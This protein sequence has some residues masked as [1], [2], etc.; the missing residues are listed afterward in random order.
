[1]TKATHKGTCQICG[2][3]QKLPSNRLSNHGYTIDWGFFNGTCAGAHGLPF[4][5]STDLIEGVIE[6]IKG[7]IKDAHKNI[8]IINNDIENSTNCLN[9]FR[10]LESKYSNYKVRKNFRG[11]LIAKKNEYGNSVVY[12]ECADGETRSVTYEYQSRTVKRITKELNQQEIG[13]LVNQISKM[14]EYIA[15]QAE[16]IT[17]WKPSELAEV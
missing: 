1:M 10:V 17:G 12:M 3:K 6:S 8:E 13:G 4:E 7:Q 2:N 14:E 15:W 16:R 9:T 11:N 5:E